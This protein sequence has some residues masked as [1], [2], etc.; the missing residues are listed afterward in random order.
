MKEFELGQRI[1]IVGPAGSGKSTVARLISSELELPHYELDEYFWGPNWTRMENSKFIKLVD[2]I[3]E[4]QKWIIEGQYLQIK[5]VLIN[6]ADT[7][8]F[9]E[10]KFEKTLFRVLKRSIFNILKKELLWNTNYQNFKN[11]KSFMLCIIKIY[12]NVLKENN[13]TLRMLEKSGVKCIKIKCKKDFQE[14][15]K[16]IKVHSSISKLSNCNHDSF[17]G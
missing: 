4:N 15:E 13:E 16:Y 12:P 5:E 10:T 3:S 1:W 9:M 2:E 14:F 8:I 6:K 17:V 11:L 7:F